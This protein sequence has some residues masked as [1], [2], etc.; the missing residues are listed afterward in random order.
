ML[1]RCQRLVVTL[2]VYS[3]VLPFLS[4]SKLILFLFFYFS[5][6]LWSDLLHF[7]F[8]L[9]L[10]FI[11]LFFFLFPFVHFLS[12]FLSFTL[13]L[14]YC[15]FMFGECFHVSV[16]FTGLWE[17]ANLLEFPGLFQVLKRILIMM[18]S[19][20]SQ[21][22]FWF[23]VYPVFFHNF[24][25]PFQVQ[26]IL[27]VSPSLS[28]SSFFSSLTTSKYLSI[29]FFRFLSLLSGSP[30]RKKPLDYYYYYYHY[31]YYYLL[32]KVFYISFS[33]WFSLKFEWQQVSSSLQDSSQYSGRSQYCCCLYGLHSSSNF[34]VLQSL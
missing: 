20:W 27:L 34:Q 9:S 18:W 10:L 7:S 14:H 15:C 13:F 19:G 6:V 1:C 12:F 21:F 25:D 3:L 31:Y 17:T 33:W 11:Q 16:S 2:H 26:Q 29:F 23:P 24:L 5:N 22:F 32:I 28:Y 30:K 8:N 4:N